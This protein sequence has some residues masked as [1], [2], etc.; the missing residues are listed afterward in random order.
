MSKWVHIWVYECGYGN[1]CGFVS[2]CFV[3]LFC[4]LNSSSLD[5][6][7]VKDF[8]FEKKRQW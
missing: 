4:L 3:C 1:Q 2:V 5:N 8:L 6:C 7:L